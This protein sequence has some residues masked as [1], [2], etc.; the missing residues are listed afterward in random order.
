[1]ESEKITTFL[2]FE[3]RTT[4]VESRRA[5]NLGLKMLAVKCYT[6]VL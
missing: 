3:Q 6:A 1:M 2:S 5:Y 4:S